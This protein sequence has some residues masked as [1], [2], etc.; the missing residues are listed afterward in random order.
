MTSACS[1][2]GLGLKTNVPIAGLRGLAAADRVDVSLVLGFMP[3]H[4]ADEAAGSTRDIYIAEELNEAGRPRI[5][6]SQLGNGSHYR[7]AYADGTRV[8]VDAQGS[9]VWATGPEGATVEDTAAYLLGPALAFVLKLRGITCLHA[10]AVAID[11]RAVAFVGPA[12][13]GK[14]SAAAAFARAGYPVLTDDVAPLHDRGTR[15]EIQPAYPRVRL[16]PDSAE[17]LFGSPEALPRITPLWG[18]RYLDLN[19]PRFEFTDRALELAA[20]YLLAPRVPGAAPAFE[21]LDSRAGL[22][23]LVVESYSRRFLDR[24]QRAREFDL[25]SRVVAN[26]PMR[27]L[28]P[29]ADLGRISGLCE[30]ILRDLERPGLPRS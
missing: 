3:A 7:L 21:A 30:A 18:K 26:V 15:F 28:S 23:A 12:G 6:V 2:Y 1:I 9:N 10:S 17:A 29:C 20:I 19:Q 5:R 25:L 14:S 4:L 8:V 13:A 27:R 22:M 16:W 24:A 11:G